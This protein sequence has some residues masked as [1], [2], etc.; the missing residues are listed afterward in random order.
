MQAVSVPA[1]P[2]RERGES[3]LSSF[4]FETAVINKMQADSTVLL[5]K[6]IKILSG[7]SI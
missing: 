4:L 1:P 3:A 7:V 2:V 5:V 6:I